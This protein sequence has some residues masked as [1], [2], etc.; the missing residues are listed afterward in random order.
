MA[1]A[2]VQLNVSQDTAQSLFDSYNRF[3]L[4]MDDPEKRSELEHAH[5]HEDLR[6]SKVWKEMGGISR[7]FHRSLIMLFMK[8]NESLCDLTMEYGL[9]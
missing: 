6:G 2:C 8:G 5:T 3:L 1:K 4:I 7:Q 9:F